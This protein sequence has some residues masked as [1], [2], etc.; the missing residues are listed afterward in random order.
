MI[1]IILPAYNEEKNIRQAVDG[2]LHFFQKT[3]LDFEIIVVNDASKDQTGAVLL[4]YQDNPFVKVVTHTQNTGCGGALHSGFL[5][6]KGDIFFY[7]D[8]DNQ[9]TIDD[10]PSF[11]EAIGTY[12]FVVGYRNPRK[13]SLI[14]VM[15]GFILRTVAHYFFGVKTKDV[16][17]AFKLFRKSMIHSLHLQEP[18]KLFNLEIFALAHQKGYTFLEL[19]V[20]HFP[21]INGRQSGANIKVIAK[22]SYRIFGLWKRIRFPVSQHRFS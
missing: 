18:V 14:R 6:A 5:A 20:R 19:P 7:T 4:E 1:S 17:C 9:F 13:D 12:D 16:N 10:I 11:L 3:L 21:R 15:Y 8:A 22:A 2:M